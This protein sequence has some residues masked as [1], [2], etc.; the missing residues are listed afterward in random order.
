M[1]P[2]FFLLSSC[3][4][5]Y[6]IHDITALHVSGI[7]RNIKN[8]LQVIILMVSNYYCFCVNYS[9]NWLVYKTTMYKGF[10]TSLS[11]KA[12]NIYSV[13]LSA[14]LFLA[15]ML[16]NTCSCRSLGRWV[17]NET[18]LHGSASCA[19]FPAWFYFYGHEYGHVQQA[20]L[21]AKMLLLPPEL[22]LWPYMPF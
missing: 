16:W 22:P 1:K 14:L 2:F 18:F 13:E 12:L 19:S 17:A 5:Q 6:N 4:I 21:L 10:I 15:M 8:V 9:E 11:S 20:V 7:K 3:L